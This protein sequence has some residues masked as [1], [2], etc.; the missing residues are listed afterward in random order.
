MLHTPLHSPGHPIVP[1]IQM[2][3]SRLL[4]VKQQEVVL[5][6]REIVQFIPYPVDEI[7]CVV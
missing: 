4:Q 5:P 1:E 3:R 7:D 6:A 2:G